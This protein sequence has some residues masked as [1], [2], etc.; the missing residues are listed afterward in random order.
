MLP[1]Q[2][3]DVGEQFVRHLDTAGAQMPDGAVEIEGVPERDGCSEQGQAGGTMALVLEST[4]AQFAEAI[5]ED[6]TG[7]RVAGL[8]LAPRDGA[9]VAPGSMPPLRR[10]GAATR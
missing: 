7:E 2:R 8:A 4:V 5:E 1:A 10:C 6:G 9:I 3:R